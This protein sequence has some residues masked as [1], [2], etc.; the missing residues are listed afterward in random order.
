MKKTVLILPFFILW[1]NAPGQ[2][3]ESGQSE[4]AEP[5]KGQPFLQLICHT[6]VYWSRTEYL[7]EQFADGYRAIDARFGIQTTGK[8]YWHQI[9]K[10]PQYGIG[11]HYADLVRDPGDTVMGNPISAFGFYSAPWARFG[12][13]SFNT[14]MAL[15]L[16]YASRIHDPETNPYNDVIASHINLFFDFNFNLGMELGKRWDLNV[17]YGVTHYSNGKIHEP[18]KGVN[19]WGWSFGLSRLFSNQSNPAVRAEFIHTHYPEFQSYEEIQIVYAA[20]VMDWHPLGLKVGQHY[21]TS[22]LTVDYAVRY[23]Y[24]SA[25][26]VG[27]DL[28]YDGSLERFIEGIPMEDVATFQK[29][30]L[31]GHLGYQFIV[32]RVTILINLGTYFLQHSYDRGFI[33][34]RWG[35]RVRLTDHL[36]TNICIKTKNGVRSDW[37]EWGL[38]YTLKVR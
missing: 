33:Y 17:G 28:L 12:R 2:E 20:G 14:D 7:K 3:A 29:T 23:S 26:T 9:H 36:H 24:R 16:S 27:V 38:A 19:N 34:S 8:K 35:G 31:A 37:I 21:F 13:F 25:V 4:S 15:G 1:L 5:L 32:D 11:V 10:F 30:Y 6:G 22:S 18:Q